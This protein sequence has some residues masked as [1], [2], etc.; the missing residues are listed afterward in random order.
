MSNIEEVKE[1][2][3]QGKLDEAM[4]I[5]MIEAMKLEIVTTNSNPEN[6]SSCRTFINVLENEIKHELGDSSLEDF[7]FSEVEKAHRLAERRFRYNPL[8]PLA[9]LIGELDG[10]GLGPKVLTL[11]GQKEQY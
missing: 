11:E 2:I 3:K 4:A 1:K 7:H 8:Y 5:A 6:A 9:F 10:L